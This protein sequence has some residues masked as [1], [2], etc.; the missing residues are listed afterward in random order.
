MGQPSKDRRSSDS[1]TIRNHPPAIPPTREA[2]PQN[3]L[4]PTSKGWECIDAPP[5]DRK[6]AELV[7]PAYASGAGLEGG[8]HSHARR[9]LAAG[10][11][12]LEVRH[13]AL[14]DFTTIGFPRSMAGLTWIKD[15]VERH[16]RL[17]ATPSM[18]L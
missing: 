2:A 6:T 5:L 15:I 11:T 18:C 4:G 17:A 14:L 9:G 12:P 1:R 16:K 7:K 10:A 3:G 13:A 8:A